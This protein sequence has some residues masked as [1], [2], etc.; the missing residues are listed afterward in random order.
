MFDI[1]WIWAP[2]FHFLFVFEWIKMTIKSSNLNIFKK[3]VLYVKRLGNA[4]HSTK[5]Q[6]DTSIFYTQKLNV[7]LQHDV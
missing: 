5:F 2:R 7:F 3:N 4:H 6:I 1:L